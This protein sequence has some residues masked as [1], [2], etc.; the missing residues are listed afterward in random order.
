MIARFALCGFAPTAPHRNRSY[1]LYRQAGSS[2]EPY[3]QRRGVRL[4][5]V[6]PTGMQQ[7]GGKSVFICDRYTCGM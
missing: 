6:W 3:F 1:V 7:R 5:G 4:I 2:G